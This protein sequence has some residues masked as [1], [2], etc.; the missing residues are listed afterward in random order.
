MANVLE[1][2]AAH[3]VTYLETLPSRQIA[4]AAGVADL[5]R[6]LGKPLPK[7]GMAA[8]AVIEELV[9]DTGGGILGSGSGRF[10]GWVIG[11]TLP[12]A[13]AADWLTSAW[14]QNSAS[15]LTAPAEAV[16]EEVCGD[17]AKELLGIPKS[18][19]FAFVT[20]CQMAH[21][22]A[23][24]AARH[25]LLRDRGRHV[26]KSG[27]IGAPQMRILTTENRQR[28][29]LARRLCYS[30]GP[31]VRLHA[32]LPRQCFGRRRS[33]RAARGVGFA[34]KTHSGRPARWS[35]QRPTISIARTA[36]A[37]S[38]HTTRLRNS[39]VPRCRRPG[40]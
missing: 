26:E 30:R 33:N 24:A 31:C 3:A 7:P 34:A 28:V 35:P 8:E 4:A 20:G 17:W 36:F 11:G 18:A 32:R 16:I 21:T 19:S 9:R 23:L 39:P 37:K 22:A 15:N 10:F 38:D 40:R 29:P 2:A 1:V 25:K 6:R 27:L 12:V 13:F 14:D 5:R